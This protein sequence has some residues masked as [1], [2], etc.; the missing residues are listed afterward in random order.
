MNTTK[1]IAISPL[2]SLIDI[3]WDGTL[4]GINT[5]W[6]SSRHKSY[7]LITDK[8]HILLTGDTSQIKY[9]SDL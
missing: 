5:P 3:F 8:G 6:H 7:L 9:K 4:I 2:E 1:R